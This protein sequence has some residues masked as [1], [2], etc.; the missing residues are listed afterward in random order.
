MKDERV[1]I[2]RDF[3]S[4]KLLF[5]LL[6]LTFSLCSEASLQA[7]AKHPAR[8][9]PAHTLPGVSKTF[10]ASPDHQY[11]ARITGGDSTP[12]F[13][14][15]YQIPQNRQKVLQLRVPGAGSFVWVPYQPHTLVV[16]ADGSAD[17]GAKARLSLWN[18]RKHLRELVPLKHQEIDGT[19]I[20]ELEGFD[21]DGVTPDGK[22]LVYNF[23]NADGGGPIN[24]RLRLPAL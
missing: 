11:E 24:V 23:L 14:C 17:T 20:R 5:T 4:S 22:V 2:T 10:F 19:D 7:Q 16:A 15:I 1:L 8:L 18:G 9:I 12:T 6:G 21:I 13:L 3:F